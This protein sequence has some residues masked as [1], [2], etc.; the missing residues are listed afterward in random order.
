MHCDRLLKSPPTLASS[1][2]CLAEVEMDSAKAG[3]TFSSNGTLP[4]LDV[5]AVGISGMA[6][7]PMSTGDSEF[8]ALASV[9]FLAC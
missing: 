3:D 1:S 2:A 4:E 7:A 9:A 8:D 5:S 6:A